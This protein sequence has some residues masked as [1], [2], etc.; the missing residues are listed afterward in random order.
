M[1]KP[2]KRGSPLSAP[3]PQRLDVPALLRVSDQ[4]GRLIRMDSLPP[5]TDMQ[6]RLRNAREGFLRQGY[7]VDELRPGVWGFA[8]RKDGRS[9]LVAIRPGSATAAAIYPATQ[10]AAPEA[11]QATSH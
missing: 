2:T 9:L 1:K 6:E 11:G 5:G 8:A 4:G 7:R 10:R 3:M